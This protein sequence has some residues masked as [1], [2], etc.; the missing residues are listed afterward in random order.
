MKASII[1]IGNSHGIRIP[2]PIIAQCGFEDEVEFSVRNNELIV[3][4]VKSSRQN[5]EASFKKMAAEGDDELL[6]SESV[7][8]AKW[9]EDEWEWR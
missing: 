4:P 8:T 5:W 1:K 2:K 3:K 6:D 7:S 9:D